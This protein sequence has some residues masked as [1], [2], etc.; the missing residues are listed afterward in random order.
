M[1]SNSS[2]MLTSIAQ[3]AERARSFAAFW[4]RM[5]GNID[6]PKYV[7]A[8]SDIFRVE[9]RDLLH[10]PCQRIHITASMAKQTMDRTVTDTPV[11]SPQQWNLDAGMGDLHHSVSRWACSLP[12]IE[13]IAPF[14]TPI[15]SPPT[16]PSI[17]S[18]LP[19]SSH[20]SKIVSKSLTPHSTLLPTLLSPT[21]AQTRRMDK[22][23]AVNSAKTRGGKARALK[24]GAAKQF[25][26]E[27][28]TIPVAPVRRAP[29]RKGAAGKTI[30]ARIPTPVNELSAP[31]AQTTARSEDVSKVLR[32]GWKLIQ[33]YFDDKVGAMAVSDYI[34]A[35]T[36]TASKAEL[37]DGFSAAISCE[38]SKGRQTVVEAI[39]E[40]LKL[41]D[42][43]TIP[44]PAK[45]APKKK[46]R[47]AFQPHFA[48]PAKGS[49]SRTPNHHSPTPFPSPRLPSG[50][51]SPTCLHLAS[52]SL[53]PS[54]P[55]PMDLPPDHESMRQSFCGDKESKVEATPVQRKMAKG[56]APVL[57][58]SVEK[59]VVSREAAKDIEVE[60]TTKLKKG[61]SNKGKGKAHAPAAQE[62]EEDPDASKETNKENKAD[63][64]PPATK[65]KKGNEKSKGKGKA[66][67]ADQQEEDKSDLEGVKKPGRLSKETIEQA[68]ALCQ[69]YH[70]ELK[71]LA[72]REGKS[73]AALLSAVG[74]TVLDSRS[75]NPW[76]AFPAG[77]VV[78][79]TGFASLMLTEKGSAL[80]AKA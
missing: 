69:A 56:K 41:L 64:D 74:D 66:A 11:D 31:A 8:L 13:S 5:G 61:K 43:S 9:F 75:L 1:N 30:E 2:A 52:S 80:N 23:S 63:P 46:K 48:G 34:D 59:P 6:D 35:V 49:A 16:S 65:P 7:A 44:K 36:D 14:R 29:K 12:A 68:Y 20:H 24:V 67:S 17:A 27:S 79:L 51:P 3:L 76:N 4:R 70:D 50:S 60:P 58:A 54:S 28:V 71:V 18:Q 78:T 47:T 62:S 39:E 45:V 26:M 72:Q 53:P 77:S 21:M 10:G 40:K 38:D 33:Q 55:C 32:D 73:V 42:N 25:I 15:K 37:Q 22:N 57:V 19:L